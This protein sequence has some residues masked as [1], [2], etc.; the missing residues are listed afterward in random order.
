MAFVKIIP[1]FLLSN[2]KARFTLALIKIDSNNSKHLCS[3]HMCQV[4][5]KELS[6]YYI[7]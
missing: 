3:V 2:K 6:N 7:H 1:K 4:L 5:F